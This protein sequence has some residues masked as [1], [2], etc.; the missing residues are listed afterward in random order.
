MKIFVCRHSELSDMR[1]DNQWSQDLLVNTGMCIT[2][3]ERQHLYIKLDY[4]KGRRINEGK[5]LDRRYH[6]AG[7]II[8]VYNEAGVD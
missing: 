1:L 6:L 7:Y 5:S 3:D 2:N 4:L 8:Q